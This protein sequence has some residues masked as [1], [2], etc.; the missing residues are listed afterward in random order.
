MSETATR[1]LM[2]GNGSNQLLWLVWELVSGRTVLAVICT[3]DDDL[4]RYVS[5]DRKHWIGCSPN[6]GT[7][8]GP[9]YVEKVYADHLYGQNDAAIA[10]R[11]MRANP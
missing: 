5:R 4:A 2:Y 10:M 8:H 9:V 3:T 6:T 1:K 11:L 7:E